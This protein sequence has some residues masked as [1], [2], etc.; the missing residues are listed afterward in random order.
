[1]NCSSLF[2]GLKMKIRFI[3]GEPRLPVVLYSPFMPVVKTEFMNPCGTVSSKAVVRSPKRL[4]TVHTFI[5]IGITLSEPRES[6]LFSFLV[7]R[8]PVSF[9]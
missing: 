3:L 7:D 9:I 8:V 2:T 1:M 5:P 4:S 6:V